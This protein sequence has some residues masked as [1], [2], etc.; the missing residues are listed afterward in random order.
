MLVAIY[1]I[2]FL[3][4][5]YRV[6]KKVTESKKDLK[7]VMNKP[8][9]VKVSGVRRKTVTPGNSYIGMRTERKYDGS[10]LRDDR[11]NDWLAGQLRDEHRA[12]KV[13]SDMFGLKIEHAAHCDAKL[14]KNYHH[15]KCDA[16]GVDTAQGH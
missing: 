4:L 9:S 12:F 3:I 7:R 10:S 16:S 8:S 14:L 2:V 6:C 1:L 13:A 5:I 11:D 15:L